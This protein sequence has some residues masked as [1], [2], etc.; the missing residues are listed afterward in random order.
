MEEMNNVLLLSEIKFS[1][2]YIIL[3]IMNSE[4]LHL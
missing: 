2:L 3:Y 4:I 1:L